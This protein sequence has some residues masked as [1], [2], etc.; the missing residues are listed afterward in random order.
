MRQREKER[1][2]ERESEHEQ[3]GEAE[4]KGEADSLLSAEHNVGLH[5]KTLRSCPEL[6]ADVEPTERPRYP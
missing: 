6:K 1:E 5:P 4:G 3:R 2:R